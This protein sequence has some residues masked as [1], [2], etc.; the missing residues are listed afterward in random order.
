[1]AQVSI[2]QNLAIFRNMLRSFLELPRPFAILEIGNFCGFTTVFMALIKQKFCPKCTFISVDPK[3]QASAYARKTGNFK[4]PDRCDARRTIK[5]ANLTNQVSVVLN[6]GLELPLPS[7]MPVGFIWYDDGKLRAANA[8]QHAAYEGRV[9]EG[10]YIG[11][12]DWG[13]K[14]PQ[15]ALSSSVKCQMIIKENSKSRGEM[16]EQCMFAKELVS[17]GQY[18][19]VEDGEAVGTGFIRKSSKV[20]SPPLPNQTNDWIEVTI[21]VDGGQQLTISREPL[22]ITFANTVHAFT[23]SKTWGRK[24]Q[25]KLFRGSKASSGEPSGIQGREKGKKKEKGDGDGWQVIKASDVKKVKGK[26]KEKIKWLRESN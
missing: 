5:L 15:D 26:G 24:N 7:D 19:L 21:S 20:Y 10:A 14:P 4:W 17:S 16:P 25:D 3:W 11:F 18:E 12:H 8:P 6:L 1:M 23:P 9:M 22:D 2:A 13:P